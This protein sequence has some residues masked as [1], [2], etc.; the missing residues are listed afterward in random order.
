MTTVP[1]PQLASPQ[2]DA[3]CHPRRRALSLAGARRLPSLLLAIL[4]GAGGCATIRVTDPGRT[5][6]EQFLLTVATTRAIDQLASAALRDRTVYV[7][8]TFL[9]AATQPASEHSFLIGELRARLLMAGVRLVPRREEAQVTLEVRSGGVGIDRYAYLI[10]IP[11]LYFGN[12][13]GTVAGPGNIPLATPEIAIVKTIK[14]RGYAGVAFVAYWNDTGELVAAS[15]PYVGRTLR[16][17]YW[18]FGYGPRTVGNIPP[19]EK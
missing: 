8:P 5:A 18:F 12:S 7:D 19:A 16:E 9:T 14:Q 4:L 17:D 2:R 6:S 11:A 15:G 1:H 3:T 13:N 10:G